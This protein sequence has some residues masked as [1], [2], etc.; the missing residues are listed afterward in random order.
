MTRRD[1]Y[2][3][4][5]GVPLGELPATDGEVIIDPERRYA[6]HNCFCGCGAFIQLPIAGQH[7]AWSATFDADGS[8]TTSPSVLNRSCQAHYFLEGGKVRWC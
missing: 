7:N 2:T 1:A 6:G 3:T 8:I 4:R 5:H